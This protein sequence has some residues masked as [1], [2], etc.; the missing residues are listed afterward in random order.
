LGVVN[1][2]GSSLPA[3]VQQASLVMP[4]DKEGRAYL[5]YDNYKA[6]MGWNRSNYFVVAVGYL[7]DRI[8]GKS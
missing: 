5:A 3:V 1:L 2:D 6:L 4:D 8:V 7:A